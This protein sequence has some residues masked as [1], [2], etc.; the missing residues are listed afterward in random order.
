MFFLGELVPA[1][2]LAVE[3]WTALRSQRAARGTCAFRAVCP[4]QAEAA[5]PLRARPPPARPNRCWSMAASTSSR[6]RSLRASIQPTTTCSP[7]RKTTASFSKRPTAAGGC[8]TGT[9]RSTFSPTN[10]ARLRDEFGA[11]FT[12][13]FEHNTAR[14]RIATVTCATVEAPGGY[15][16]TL[17]LRAGGASEDAVR[18]AL[19]SSRGYV[20]DAGDVVLLPAGVVERLTAVQGRLSAE[21]PPRSRRGA[22]CAL[23]G[24]VRRRP[25]ACWSRSR[26]ISSRRR[27]GGHGAAPCAICRNSNRHPCRRRSRHAIAALPAPRRGLAV[28]PFPQRAWRHSRGRDGP[29]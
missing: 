17:A 26:R 6:S 5:V 25:R 19:A 28:A 3:R 23:A 8:A 12:P 18:A 10:W 15:D 16:V 22:R 27:P 11:R 9:R 13:N 4:V 7:W 20:E 24:P 1:H 2:A 21:P 14:L 29:G